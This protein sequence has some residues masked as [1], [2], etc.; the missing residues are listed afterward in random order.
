MMQANLQTQ[1][2]TSRGAPIMLEKKL[3]K[4]VCKSNEKN[5][6]KIGKFWAKWIE[7]AVC[8]H[9][10]HGKSPNI[11]KEQSNKILQLLI[12]IMTIKIL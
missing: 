5:A 10:S 9:V 6:G 3:E 4:Q 11:F 1:G 2:V 7:V 8:N 12:I